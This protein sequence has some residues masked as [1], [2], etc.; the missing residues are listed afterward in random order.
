MDL[1]AEGSES[2]FSDYVEGL[3]GVIEMAIFIGILIVGFWY[4]WKKGALE[5]D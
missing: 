1:G 5:W 4:A 3:V 2:R